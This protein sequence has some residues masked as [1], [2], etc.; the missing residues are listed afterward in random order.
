MARRAALR[1]SWLRWFAVRVSVSMAVWLGVPSTQ[2]VSLSGLHMPGAA[3]LANTASRVARNSGVIIPRSS[4]MPS[5]CWLPN[6]SPRR[7]A[8]SSS[9]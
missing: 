9:R 6:L 1:P 2:G 8:R 7:R 4:D 3:S 5:D